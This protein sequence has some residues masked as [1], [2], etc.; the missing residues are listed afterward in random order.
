MAAAAESRVGTIDQ[1]DIAWLRRRVRGW[2]D[3]HGRSFPWRLTQDPYEVLAA[4]LLL[5]RTRADLVSATYP[6]FI[7]AYPNANALAQADPGELVELLRPLGFLHRSRRLL[8]VGQALVARF[9]G[10]VP[11]A[12]EDLLSLPGV[13]R[14]VAN[15]VLLV[16]FNR[17]RA[18]LD[19]NVIRL[20]DRCF[21]VRSA[22]A[23]A[24]EDV[25]LWELLEQVVPPRNPRPVALG[26]IDLG[27]TVC[28][29]RRPRCGVCPL[30]PRCTAY[31]AGLVHP[32]A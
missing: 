30:R 4:E 11:T 8:E 2:F 16:A 28:V 25:G 21:G 27:A 17:P 10:T 31:G 6:K 32:A 13:G 12:P 1:T 3:L 24:R 5:Q 15:A 29:P 20:L 23:R 14:Y 19:P 18:L 9:G 22:R 7:A 26:L